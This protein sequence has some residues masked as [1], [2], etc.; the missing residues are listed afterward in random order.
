MILSLFA[1]ALITAIAGA[2]PAPAAAE[3]AANAAKPGTLTDLT[4][5]FIAFAD[6][7]AAMPDAAR[8]T[9]FH[10]RFDPL[11]PGYYN[12][13][14]ASQARFDTMIAFGLKSFPA[15]RAKFSTTATS[16]AAAFARG[17]QHFRATF[18]DYRLTVPVYLVHSMSQQ[19]GGTRTIA[20][21]TVLMFGA[22]M[23]ATLHDETTIGAFLDHELFHVYHQRAFGDCPQIWCSLWQEG[24]ATYAASRLNPGVS[25][26]ALLLTVPRPIR[27]AVE[28]RLAEAMCAVRAKFY[29]TAPGDYAPLFSF[30]GNGPFPPRYGYYVGYVLAQKLGEKIPLQRLAK[31]RP[32]AV[33]PLLLAAIDGYGPCA[34]PAAKP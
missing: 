10:D 20:G 8:V 30:G 31:L 6:E 33:K 24:L 32:A 2:T 9:A 34:A 3:L 23:I 27:P 1:G 11:L 5:A 15:I 22:D 21:R 28:P 14:G 12:D 26:R 18:P 17:Q 19:D 16:F 29:S 4:P 7:T 25:D 13:K